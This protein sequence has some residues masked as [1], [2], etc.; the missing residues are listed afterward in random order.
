[1][2]YLLGLIVGLAALWLLLSGHYSPLLLGLGGLSCLFTAYICHR[3]RLID[4]ETVP[5][6]MLHRLPGYL[7]W[8]GLEIAK[9]NWDVAQRILR[10]GRHI[11]P[12]MIT[13]RA[14]QQSQLGQVIFANSITLTPGTVT[15]GLRGGVAEVHAL[16][17]DNARDMEG[18]EMDKRVRALESGGASSAT[19]ERT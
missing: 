7:F 4:A 5:L 19:A 15:V 3:M 6:H 9:S 12:T 11:S 18:G 14:R 10:P 8:L 16:T 2:R 1:M 17:E 13:L